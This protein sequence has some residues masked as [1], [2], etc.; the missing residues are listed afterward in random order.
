[1]DFSQKDKPAADVSIIAANY[2]NGDYIGMFIESVA[3]SGVSRSARELKLV[4]R[5]RVGSIPVIKLARDAPH[6]GT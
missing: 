1:M 3:A 4:K 6:T 2:N 5:D